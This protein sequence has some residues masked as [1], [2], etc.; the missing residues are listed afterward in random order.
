MGNGADKILDECIKNGIAVRGVFASDGFVRRQVFR[1]FEVMSFS[2]AKAAS[3]D[4][5]ALLCFGSALP[6]V[7][8]S[9]K[10]KAKQVTLLSPSVPVYGCNVFNEAFYTEN[11]GRINAARKLFADEYSK[12]VFDAIISYRLSGEI[13]YLFGIQTERD[14]NYR[15]LRLENE[16]YADLGAYRGESITEVGSL[17]RLDKVYA[18]EPDKKTFSKLERNLGGMENVKVFNCAVGEN[19]GEILFESKRGRG[20]SVGSKGETIMQRSLDSLFEN[21]KVSFIKM[22]VEGNERAALLGARNTIGTQL[23]KL[24]I[25]CYHRSEDIFSLPLLINEISDK[26][27]IYLRHEPSLPD[28]DTDIFAIIK[29]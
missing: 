1:G 22:D 13:G 23:P 7:I 21:E 10:E 25:A 5:I 20:S 12:K 3:P 11:E 27:A 18:V 29:E 28:W 19:D 8:A 2:E 24:K 17:C 14:E 15:L 6:E 16:R 4:M 26:Y 9:V